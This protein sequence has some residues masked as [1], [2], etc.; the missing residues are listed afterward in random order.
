MNND[1]NMVSINFLKTY[2]SRRD[3]IVDIR[4][5]EKYLKSHIPGAK[6]Y[7][8]EYLLDNFNDLKRYHRVYIY[9]DFGNKGMKVVK[10][11]QERYSINNVYNVV[12]GFNIYRGKI[13]RE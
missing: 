6:N 9:C 13:E 1:I 12:G 2:D 10:L 3:L 7:N 4:E 8:V 11:L 5:K